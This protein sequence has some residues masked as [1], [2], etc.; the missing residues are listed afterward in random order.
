MRE[1]AGG[2]EVQPVARFTEQQLNPYR[3]WPFD[4]PC[5]STGVLESALLNALGGESRPQDVSSR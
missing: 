4:Q 3:N 2:T 1:S 5:R